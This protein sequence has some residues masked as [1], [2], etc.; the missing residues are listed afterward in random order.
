MSGPLVVGMLAVP[1]RTLRDS[2]VYLV[3]AGALVALGSAWL[4]TAGER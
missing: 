1:A 2:L 4:I 3:A